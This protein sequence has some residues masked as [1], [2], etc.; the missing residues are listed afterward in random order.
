MECKGRTIF[1]KY[2]GER[3]VKKT[4]RTLDNPGRIFWVCPM[5]SGGHGW[6]EWGD[7]S[8]Y[9]KRDLADKIKGLEN[10][11][12]DLEESLHQYEVKKD[13]LAMEHRIFKEEK[14]GHKVFEEMLQRTFFFFS[15]F[16]CF[17]Y[18]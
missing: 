14:S 7:F 4:S 2:C 13:Q 15:N 12:D 6:M 5:K 9:P 18:F 16:D 11:V 1:Y 3:C 10:L 17:V 8:S